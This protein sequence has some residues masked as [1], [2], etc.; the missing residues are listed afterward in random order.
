MNVI[1]AANPNGLNIL[2]STVTH[3]FATHT[4]TTV[5]VYFSETVCV[6][7]IW[8]WVRR[9]VPWVSR[10]LS[11][12]KEMTKTTAKSLLCPP[13]LSLSHSLH[14]TYL[15]LPLLQHWQ[16]RGH[17][18]THMVN[19]NVPACNWNYYQQGAN[20]HCKYEPS[21]VSVTGILKQ[22][23]ILHT[24]HTELWIQNI[25]SVHHSPTSLC[26]YLRI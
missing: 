23:C 18:S 19:V 25:Y 11:S 8:W 9:R 21:L 24:V 4:L 10:V 17:I 26:Q 7:T 5:C 12:K 2:I 15:T 13:S 20:E 1:M 14:P 22:T 16:A 3:R 6:F